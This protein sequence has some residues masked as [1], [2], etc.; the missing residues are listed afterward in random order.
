MWSTPLSRSS[1]ADLGRASR[2]EASNIWDHLDGDG[3][4][5]G[6]KRVMA[7]LKAYA[8][9]AR[10]P[11]LLLPPTLVASGAAAAA[12]DGAFSWP[13]TLLATVG[14]V[15]LHMAVNILNEWSDLRTGIDL[16]TERTPFSGGSGTLPSGAMA[17]R[18]ALIFGLACAGVGLAIG[19]W[20]LVA[21]GRVFLPILVVGAV[22]V[23]AYTDALARLGIGEVA[24]GIG[25]GALPVVGAALVQDGSFSPASAAAAIPAFCMT[26]NLLFLNEFPDE[27]ADRDGGRRNLV[28]LFGRKPAARVYLLVGLVVPLSVAAAV[29]L[30]VLPLICLAAAL[31][32]LLLLKPARWALGDPQSPV[33]I[34][35][36][37]ANVTWNLATNSV[38]ALALIVAILLRG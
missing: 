17:S 25:L 28:I 31:P 35:A 36:L 32:S 6:A 19:L 1:P 11:F 2:R 24:A 8:G 14:L 3:D 26:F 22:C 10:A 4:G 5:D 21:I 7:K 34:P 13:H 29:V 12:W 37:A 20:F 18:T 9:V 33:P 15:A 23:L 16:A 30:K 38:M 27:A